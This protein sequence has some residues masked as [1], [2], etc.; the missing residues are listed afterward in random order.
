MSKI[1]K[2]AKD[3][4][5]NAGAGAGSGWGIGYALGGSEPIGGSD[6]LPKLRK[7]KEK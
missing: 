1:L 6:T 7:K 5:I 3:V 2:K 4:L